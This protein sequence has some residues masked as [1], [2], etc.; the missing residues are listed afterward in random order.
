MAGF[1]GGIPAPRTGRV[2]VL[3]AAGSCGTPAVL[4]GASECRRAHC[5]CAHDTHTARRAKALLQPAHATQHRSRGSRFWPHIAGA[6]AHRDPGE[7]GLERRRHIPL[8]LSRRCQTD[9]GGL[10]DVFL[11]SVLLNHTNRSVLQ[12]IRSGVRSKRVD[13]ASP[14]LDGRVKI[15]YLLSF[16]MVFFMVPRT[17]FFFHVTRRVVIKK[18]R[19]EIH[20][21]GMI[22]SSEINFRRL[23]DVVLIISQQLAEPADA[24]LPLTL[25]SLRGTRFHIG[26]ISL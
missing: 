17:C 10:S 22:V 5:Q 16:V 20:Q 23:E 7:G 26:P 9:E 14:F 24:P 2:R 4:G 18:V 21:S 25:E 8:Q 6:G 15:F 11:A 12:C 19:C 13:T 3:A 1:E